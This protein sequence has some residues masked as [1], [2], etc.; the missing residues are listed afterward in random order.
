MYQLNSAIKLTWRNLLIINYHNDH[1]LELIKISRNKAIWG[2]MPKQYA[3]SDNFKKL[4]LK[5]AIDQTNKKERV[6]LSVCFNEKIMGS[7]SF[8]NMCEKHKKVSIGYSWIHPRLWGKGINS[9][10]K[11]L[12]LE[13]VFET[14]CYNRVE[15]SVD[16][17]NVRSCAALLKIG[18]RKEGL[19]RNH[20]ILCDGRIRHS[21][22]SSV[23]KEEWDQ[24]KL[25]I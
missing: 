1:E 22:I 3:L 24:I 7:T 20:Y 14:L 13:Y 15:F 23:I 21:A 2:Y 4:W 10:I 9:T 19:L 12:L 5:T 8:Y 18:A 6:L 11:F 25:S 16:S 17:L